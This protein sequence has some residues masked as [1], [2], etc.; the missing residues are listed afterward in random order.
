M[1]NTDEEDSESTRTFECRACGD[2][3]N[4]QVNSAKNLFKKNSLWDMLNL[5]KKQVLKLLIERGFEKLIPK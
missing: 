1:D 4:A 5:S 2:E 3:I